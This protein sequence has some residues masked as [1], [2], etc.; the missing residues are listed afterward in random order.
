[1]GIMFVCE[2]SRWREFESK[3]NYGEKG[4]QSKLVPW[5]PP[6]L[7][8][9]DRL[10]LRISQ[11][12]HF[13]TGALR[14]AAPC[15]RHSNSRPATITPWPHGHPLLRLAARSSRSSEP[16]LTPISAAPLQHGRKALH[17]RRTFAKSWR[18]E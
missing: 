10:D 18:R 12:G 5:R 7:G 4:G 13:Q 6:T 11:D 9:R 1:M 8:G 16:D 15:A 17:R 3:S 2:S 14:G